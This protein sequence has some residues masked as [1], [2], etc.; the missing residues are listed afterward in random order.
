LYDLADPLAVTL[1]VLGNSSG[2]GGGAFQ[3]LAKNN[4][5]HLPALP[6][7]VAKIFKPSSVVDLTTSVNIWSLYCI[8]GARGG[9]VG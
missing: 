9:A 8:C 2:R 1:M 5:R 6:Y 3:L 7:G 4:E